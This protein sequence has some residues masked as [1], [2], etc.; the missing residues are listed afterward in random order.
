MQNARS[1]WIQELPML[2]EYK[3]LLKAQQ[4]EW[5]KQQEQAMAH[6]VS[7][8][9]FSLCAPPH[10]PP[11]PLLSP[12]R[13]PPTS[14]LDHAPAPCVAS[15]HCTLSLSSGICSCLTVGKT[16]HLSP[17]KL[18][19]LSVI[20]VLRQYPCFISNCWL[21]LRTGLCFSLSFDTRED[22]VSCL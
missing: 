7:A 8:V 2:A 6:R 3:A 10:S 15:S 16:V 19:S 18:L 9:Q 14:A 5:A 4:Q 22:S 1:R 11:I 21:P 17:L 20:G 12:L 13:S